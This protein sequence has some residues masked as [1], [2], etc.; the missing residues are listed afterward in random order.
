VPSPDSVLLGLQYDAKGQTD[1]IAAEMLRGTRREHGNIA[2]VGAPGSG[3]GLMIKAN[4]L[5]WQHSVVVVDLKGDTYVD[6]ANFRESELKQK[7]YVLDPKSATG[8]RFDPVAAI[9]RANRRQLA[10]EIVSRGDDLGSGGRFWVNSALAWWLA[11]WAAADLE[12][13]PHMPFAVQLCEMGLAASVL[14]LLERHGGV[15]GAC[16]TGT[17]QG[18]A[19]QAN[20]QENA[21]GEHDEVIK[22]LIAFLGNHPKLMTVESLLEPSKLLESK[23]ATVVESVTPFAHPAIMRVFSGNDLDLEGLFYEPASI[24]V[25]A[26]ETNEETFSAFLQLTM[27]ALGDALIR[28]G[29]RTSFENRRPI[30][31]LFDEFGRVQLPSALSWLDTMRSRGIVLVL[32][33]QK[34]S[35]IQ[36]KPG[37]SGGGRWEDDENSVHHWVIYKPTTTANRASMFI[38]KLSGLATM[39]VAGGESTS[40]NMD[41]SGGSISSSVTYREVPVVRGEDLEEL[42]ADAVFFVVNHERTFKGFAAGI[43]PW[44]LFSNADALM[45]SRGLPDRI[46]KP[47]RLLE[48]FELGG[49]LERQAARVKAG[50]RGGLAVLPA[51]VDLEDARAGEAETTGPESS[52]PEM[53]E[54][55]GAAGGAVAWDDLGGFE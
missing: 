17:G 23:W 51:L 52:D 5:N 14:Y 20:A 26:D 37:S 9:P 40:H 53:L 22:P 8:H 31:F 38:S 47:G 45:Q 48:A 27:K 55:R 36:G 35:Q 4:L 50:G 11:V 13:Q 7:I 21:R 3:K 43:T 33:L 39:R 42:G 29:D 12:G 30:L 32:F 25:M 2:V 54:A 28:I 49:A 46:A 34:F 6:T 18:N 15:A 24:Y 44:R 1:L 41:A 10:F 19:G 16:Q